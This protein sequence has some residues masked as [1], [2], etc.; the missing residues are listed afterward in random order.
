[1]SAHEMEPFTL[2]EETGHPAPYRM[3]DNVV[4]LTSGKT[5][6]HDLSYLQ[7]LREA[8]PDMIGKPSF[9]P[10]VSSRENPDPEQELTVP[11]S[12][13]L[14]TAIPSYNLPLRAFAAAGLATC[15]LDT[16]TDSFASFRGFNGPT[17]RA[18]HGTLAETVH[19]AKYQY[20][21]SLENFIVY[22]V[23]N[24][25]YVLASRRE[26]EDVFGPSAATDS[27]MQ[28]VGGW[29]LSDEEVVWVYD[30]YWTR[31]KGL[32]REVMK[33]D[34]GK[35]ILDE[36]VKKDLTGVTN[37]FFDSKGVY[38][39]LGVPWK[40]GLLFRREKLMCWDGPDGP[41]G[42]GKTISIK[43][44]MHTLLD[45]EDPIPTLYVRNAPQTYDISRV[46]SQARALSPCMLIL[47]DV[48]TIVTPQ[49]RSY[50]FNEMDGLENNDGLFIVA[51]TNFL[52]RLDTGLSKRPSRFDRKYLFPLPNEHER[53]L[54]CEYWRHKLASNKAIEF[55]KQLSP[56]MAH[57][58]PHF[59]FAFLQECFVATLLILARQEEDLDETV[60]DHD[61]LNEYE[62]WRVFRSQAD[63]LRKEVESK[64]ERESSTVTNVLMPG[65]P[66]A[67]AYR[68][69]R[70][71]SS[72]LSAVGGKTELPSLLAHARTEDTGKLLPALSAQFDKSEHINETAYEMRI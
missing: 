46:F 45:R 44:L 67:G 6:D 43:A 64:E 48:E 17:R 5:A 60:V 8:N 61:E 62:L 24:V 36:R 3:F 29:L 22:L 55:P 18:D 7:A 26:G 1:M 42:N 66:L 4:D 14:V 52:E 10:H 58:T 56:A 70:Q 71:P 2:V 40:R 65:N 72:R 41:P 28:A 39:D 11:T 19:F 25:Q 51:S 16:T 31:S 47:E 35:V 49:T 33:A 59:S 57:I 53:T 50:F 30:R 54:Y 27:L 21:W 63:I 20:T 32:Y 13:H 23:A 34:W 38:E 15:T 9:P 69:S 68:A 12:P 37:K